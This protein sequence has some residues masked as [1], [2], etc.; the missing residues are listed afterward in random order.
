MRKAVVINQARLE[1]IAVSILQSCEHITS[2]RQI[3][4]LTIQP[5]SQTM[6]IS[7]IP[8][9]DVIQNSDI[10]RFKSRSEVRIQF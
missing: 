10:R 8:Y 2:A 9:S 3:A 5:W 1:P 6:I 7:D 4:V